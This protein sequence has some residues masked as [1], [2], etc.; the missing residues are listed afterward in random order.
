MR[1]VDRYLLRQVAVRYVAVVTVVVSLLLLENAHRLA[2]D[3]VDTTDPLRLL[4]RLSLMLVPEHLAVASPVAL[5]LA[6]ALTVRALAMRGEWQM[7][8]VGRMSPAR[9]LLAPLMLAV[10]VAGLQ[11]AVRLEWRPGG[12]RQ[13]DAL[14]HQ[15]A[16]GEH[17]TP[18][19]TREPLVLAPGTTMVADGASR[20]DGVVMLHD[21]VV[22]QA[23]DVLYA[24]RAAV[25]SMT[26]GGIV[27]DLQ[28]GTVVHVTGRDRW[29]RIGFAHLNVGGAAPGLALTTGNARLRLDRLGASD[30][31][32]RAVDPAV[33]DRDA[34][35][36]AL[37]ARIESAVF[38]LLLPWLGMILGAPPLRRHG[39]AGLLV[40]IAL[41]VVHGQAAGAIED[42]L[43][44]VA[45]PAAIVHLL[46]WIGV[47]AVAARGMQAGW[48]PAVLAWTVPIR[49]TLAALSARLKTSRQRRE[50]ETDQILQP[51]RHRRHPGSDVG[52]SLRDRGLVPA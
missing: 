15:I 44:R 22:H 52:D 43:A 19:P 29:R 3:L 23:G 25:V 27:L 46:A 41:I 49:R 24:P 32:A 45:V 38:L 35:R 28:A 2:G 21:V 1:I 31:W 12:E 13:L 51:D 10:A 48:R 39:A 50:A 18:I 8:A 40:G 30:L 7:F 33:T 16:S 26:R 6:V 14:Y 20:Q 4:G 42:N 5:F 11:L 37:M 17:G 36:A 47:V 9:T 34:A